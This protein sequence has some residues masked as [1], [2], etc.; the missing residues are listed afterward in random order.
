[1][2]PC[3]PDKYKTKRKTPMQIDTSDENVFIKNE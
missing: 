1:M 3:E 2:F